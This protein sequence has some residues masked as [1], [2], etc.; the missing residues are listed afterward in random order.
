MHHS[1]PILIIHQGALGDLVM[2]LPALYSL[3]LF[4]EGV[5]WTM[6]GNPET[7][8]LLHNRFYGQDVI[9]FHQKEWAHLFQEDTEIPQ[10]FKR[11]LS[12]FQKAF[13]FSAHQ[14]ERLIQG[15]NR[16]GLKNI[17]CLPSYP[18][19]QKGIILKN[20]QREILE[21]ENIPW[22]EPEKTLFP[23]PEDLRKAF[24]YLRNNLRLE[25]G[26]SLWAI[27]PGS[28]S[29]HKNWPLE[30]FL[31][32]AGKLRER[33]QVQPIFL[34]GPVEQETDPVSISAI[35]NQ[36]FL[37]AR[38]LSL[39]VLAGV[40]SYCSGYLGNDSGVSHLA[41]ALG[42]PTV[43]I[44]GPTDPVFWSPQGTAVKILSSNCSC[45]PCARETRQSC[46]TKE[47]LTSLSVQEVLEAIG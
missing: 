33:N 34:S 46:P 41:A 25:E 36:G 37:I 28:G 29:R 20:L 18:D 22:L 23:V 5:P 14:P 2:S 3:R 38:N 1:T 10:M 40:L 24:E 16:A 8:S 42:I 27:H 39:P 32:T 19:I 31:E 7:L 4:Y 26:R 11:Y 45:A 9:S 6:V 35:Q 44:F 17:F 30:R 13:L 43:V 12:S 21:S 15:L 47:C